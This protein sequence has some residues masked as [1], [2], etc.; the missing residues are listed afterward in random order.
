L[1]FDGALYQFRK[2]KKPASAL[3]LNKRCL[4]LPDLLLPATEKLIQPTT[5]MFSWLEVSEVYATDLQ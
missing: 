3:E 2:K 5:E 1:F 4:P